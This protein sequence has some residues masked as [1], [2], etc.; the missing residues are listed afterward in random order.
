MPPDAIRFCTL[1]SGSSGNAV[2]LDCPDGAV[3]VDAGIS[4]KRVAA[5]L[6]TVGAAP[7]RLAAVVVTHS[8]RDHVHAAGVLA[9]RHG[10]PLVMSE[11]TARTAAGTL[12]RVPPPRTFTPGAS[13]R[14][15]GFV[16]ETVPTPH[17]A[18]GSVALV[19]RR[20]ETAVGVLTDLGH[21]F[22]GLEDVVAD[23]DAAVLE[24]NHDPDLL[25]ATTRY[26]EW[27]KR[28]IR[29][30]G[31]HIANA[32]AA[33]LVADHGGDRLRA[34][35]LAHLSENSNT[36]ETALACHRTAHAERLAAGALL[37]DT[38][39][40]HAPSPLFTIAPRPKRSAR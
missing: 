31:G 32:E 36:P 8:H 12:G 9:R 35:L 10:L 11:E 17:D 40:R 23:L 39:P 16:I 13:L 4:G 30:R 25:A 24:S 7:E 28:R 19:L 27:L 22:D 14:L 2:Y 29:G 21:T 33:A 6:H 15:G 18:E 5:G 34:V 1:A 26:P 3:L 38:A 20:G 37:L